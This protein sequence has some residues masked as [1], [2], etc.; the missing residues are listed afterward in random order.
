MY[1]K[2]INETPEAYS[3]DQ[4]FSDNPDTS[5]PAVIPDEVLEEFNVYRIIDTELPVASV[6]EI[7]EQ[8]GYNQLPDG[9]WVANWV[10]R[11]MNEDELNNLLKTIENTR[12]AAYEDEADPLFFKVQRGEAALEE[13][14]AKILEIKTRYPYPE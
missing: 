10:V 7:I 2:L 14:Q 8:D 5:F 12:K 4:L 6:T 1:I 9:S 3:L 13:W 11:P